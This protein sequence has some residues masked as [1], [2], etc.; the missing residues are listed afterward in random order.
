M[1]TEKALRL[2]FGRAAR[3]LPALG[4]HLASLAEERAALPALA[5][6]VVPGALLVLLRGRDGGAG[7]LACDAGFVA[8]VIEAETTGRLAPQ[9]PP[10]RPPTR[11]DAVIAGGF[12]DAA[13][14][15]FDEAAAELPG[16]AALTGFRAAEAVAGPQQLA[17]TLDDVAYR[18][19]RLGFLFGDGG[20]SGTVTIALPWEPAALA[21]ARGA[22]ALRRDLAQAVLAAPAE[23]HAVLARLA[24]PLERVSAWA[25]GDTVTLP[26][27]ALDGVRLEDRDG[28]ALA[29]GRLGQ[30]G[31]QRAVR[32]RMPP[33]G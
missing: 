2:A 18:V 6:G 1:T 21:A 20:R 4:L 17:L 14:A 32:L 30:A 8:A 25:P 22:E 31:G 3:A 24:L 26:R 28:T 5:E 13:L 15:A 29:G 10:A 16:A 9:P 11:I 12:C 33:A 23:L 27:E 7:A 19:L